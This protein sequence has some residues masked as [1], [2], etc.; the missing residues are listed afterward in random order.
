MN[1]IDG[2]IAISGYRIT[3]QLYANSRNL[4]CRGIREQNY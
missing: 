1:T 2:K 4:I 3:K